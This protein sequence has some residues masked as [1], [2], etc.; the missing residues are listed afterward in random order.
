M[1]HLNDILQESILDDADDIV[2]SGEKAM[3]LEQIWKDLTD[4][5]G[6]ILAGSK[7]GQISVDNLDFDKKGRIIFKNWPGPK[8]EFNLSSID[9]FP[10]IVLK[11]GFGDFD[12]KISEIR[13][14]QPRCKL[15]ELGLKGDYSKCH[16]LIEQGNIEMDVF[17]KVASIDF[18]D[19]YFKNVHIL[20]K[21]QP[22]QC[23]VRFSNLSVDALFSCW[24][25]R[26]FNRAVPQ[27][28]RSGGQNL[29]F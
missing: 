9:S 21:K 19:T 17:P 15:S 11:H 16:V 29:T 8:I 10:E 12:K 13:F 7:T 22:K 23:I 28:D 14:I 2:I 25:Y 24:A 5:Y 20:P 1:K 27:W 18:N 4:T 26:F 6:E 3:E